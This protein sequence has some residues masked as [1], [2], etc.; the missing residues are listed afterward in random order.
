M[1]YLHVHIQ[2]TD[3]NYVHMCHP[4]TCSAP[5]SSLVEDHIPLAL[6]SGS[7]PSTRAL[8]ITDAYGS[9]PPHGVCLL[10]ARVP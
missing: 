5:H 1:L 6:H 9:P 4:P 7:Q 10:A 8:E 3:D 2:L